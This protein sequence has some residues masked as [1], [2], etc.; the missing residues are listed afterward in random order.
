[1]LKI[2]FRTVISCGVGR[3]FKGNSSP[4]RTLDCSAQVFPQAP[5]EQARVSAGAV[6]SR[7]GR[8][9]RPTASFHYAAGTTPPTKH[10]GNTIIKI[11]RERAAQTLRLMGTTQQQAKQQCEPWRG[12]CYASQPRSSA[13]AR[14]LRHRRRRATGTTPQAITAITAVRP[15]MAASESPRPGAA[16]AR[17]RSTSA[18]SDLPGISIWISKLISAQHHCADHKKGAAGW[19]PSRPDCCTRWSRR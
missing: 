2:V 5:P 17:T 18:A 7:S 1:M 11:R 10:S 3:F 12:S 4:P 9:A 19:L 6:L 15:A 8:A 14:G 16:H 13:T